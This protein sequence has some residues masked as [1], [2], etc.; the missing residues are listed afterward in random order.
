MKLELTPGKT[1]SIETD[2]EYTYGKIGVALD[3]IFVFNL[4]GSQTLEDA[5]NEIDERA[6]WHGIDE[7]EIL[8][9]IGYEGSIDELMAD[10]LS[11]I[12]RL[13]IETLL[14]KINDKVILNYE[15][16]II[17]GEETLYGMINFEGDNSD[18]KSIDRLKNLTNDGVT[19]STNSIENILKTKP[20]EIDEVFIILG[21]NTYY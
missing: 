1:I 2:P 8:D 17:N 10:P 15:N 19:D 21:L 14:S 6:E 18:E 5:L 3:D 12:S 16:Q 7:Q 4:Y 13:Y 11:L 20:W 9:E